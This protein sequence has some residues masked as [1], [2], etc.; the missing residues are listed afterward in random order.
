MFFSGHGTRVQAPGSN[1][2]NN[3]ALIAQDGTP[4]EQ[5]H[6]GL[7]T[8]E[9]IHEV[10]G[11]GRRKKPRRRLRGRPVEDDIEQR[12]TMIFDCCWNDARTPRLIDQPLHRRHDFRL[13]AAAHP[14]QLA[15]EMRLDGQP[16]G[17]FTWALTTAMSRWRVI[18][19]EGTG[20]FALTANHERLMDTARDLMHALGV[21]EQTPD[22][23]G[24]QSLKYVPVFH[25]DQ[26]WDASVMRIE[27]DAQEV[28]RQ[29][30]GGGVGYT[31]GTIIEG[32]PEE[33]LRIDV[34]GGVEYW[35][36]REALRQY[37]QQ[38][39]FGPVQVGW[40]NEMAPAS[41]RGQA[42]TATQT[43]ANNPAAA[44]NTPF[45]ASAG[46]TVRLLFDA[47]WG[48]VM[49]ELTVDDAT[50]PTMLVSARWHASQSAIDGSGEPGT[51]NTLVDPSFGGGPH[52]YDPIAA[53]QSIVVRSYAPQ[54]LNAPIP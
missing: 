26:S 38:A 10:F 25:P 48:P 4:A 8:M 40:A 21:S 34:D 45:A 33:I 2:N 14:G 53:S 35:F 31:F 20:H 39:T 43:M 42:V 51:P 17:A 32:V 47:Q 28:P 44:A 18:P 9:D 37:F 23:I 12:L 36:V 41:E 11:L 22:L 16:T 3:L 29:V 1:D 15:Y 6:D 24:R 52:T 50:N 5:G 46:T 19:V 54:T 30:W 49:L 27:P 7:V 13:M